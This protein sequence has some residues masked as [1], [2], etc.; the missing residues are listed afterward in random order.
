MSEPS[1]LG[2]PDP[3]AALTDNLNQHI[4]AEAFKPRA[5]PPWETNT[6]QPPVPIPEEASSN[7][8][9]YANGDPLEDM[10]RG[11]S[12]QN[13][14]EEAPG[15]LITQSSDVDQWFILPWA[16]SKPGHSPWEF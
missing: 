16:T 2:G 15:N 3:L 6:F 4:T 10:L 13:H 7:E 5:P 9:E 11:E 8:N 12:S 14:A 1:F